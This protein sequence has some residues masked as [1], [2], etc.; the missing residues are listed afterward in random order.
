MKKS[1]FAIFHYFMYKK[2]MVV[3]FVFHFVQLYFSSLHF[4]RYR[5]YNT[6]VGTLLFMYTI[7]THF[8]TKLNCQYLCTAWAFITLFPSWAMF[9]L[10]NK[11]EL[12]FS[13]C[14]MVEEFSNSVDS[15]IVVNWILPQILDN[16]S[17]CWDL[18]HEDW[19]PI[20]ILVF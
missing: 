4:L 19:D 18:Y 17:H 12:V 15:I 20:T 10:W 3:F 8:T 16:L 13:S 1:I 9:S 14:M 5:D 6:A 2:T 7:T 11:E